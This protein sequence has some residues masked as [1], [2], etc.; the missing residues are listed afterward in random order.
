MTRLSHG[1]ATLTNFRLTPLFAALLLAFHAQR[2]QASPPPATY[3]LNTA[4]AP[5]PLTGLWWNPDEPGWGMSLIQQG[6]S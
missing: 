1:T 5:S 6:P 4:S 2:A 3:T